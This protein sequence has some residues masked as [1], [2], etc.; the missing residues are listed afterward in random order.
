MKAAQKRPSGWD[1]GGG[2]HRE[3][4]GRYPQTPAIDRGSRETLKQRGHGRRHA[5][6]NDRWD[7]MTKD[8]QQALGRNKRDVWE[9][10]T[11]PF[12]GAHFATFPKKL[13]E[14]CILAGSRPGDLV[15]DPFI[16]S[17]TTAEVAQSLGRDWI[18]CEINPEYESMIATRTRQMG[19][20]V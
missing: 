5:G 6:F 20:E 10:A 7:T 17:G 19:M 2:G 11:Q 15:L 18:G 4:I 12:A 16:G 3:K 14:P 13:V 8:E 9:I 1:A